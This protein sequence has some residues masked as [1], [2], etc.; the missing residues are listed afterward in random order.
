MSDQIEVIEVSRLRPKEATRP[1][2]IER[3]VGDLSESDYRRRPSPVD[4]FESYRLHR[5][6]FLLMVVLPTL[7]A[8]LYYGLWASDQYAAEVRFGVRQ[9]QQPNVSDDVLAKMAQGMAVGTTG[10]EPYLVA[11]YVRSRNLVEELDRQIG[12]REIYSRPAA[13]FF[14]RFDP[15]GSSEKLWGYWRDMVTV[16]ADRFSGLVTVRALAF[17]PD[18]AVTIV[19]AVQVSAEQIIDET[20]QRPRADALHF[21]EDELVRARQRYVDSLLALR[22]VREGAQTVDPATAIE[23]T[24]KTLTGAIRQKL[25]LERDLAFNMKVVSPSAPQIQV[26]NQ[27]LRAVNEQIAALNR[28]LTSRDEAD[29]TAADVISRFEERE[30]ARRFSEKLMEITQSSYER[31]RVEEARQHTYLTSFVEPVR[32]DQAEYPRRARTIGLIAVLA[33]VVWTI[34]LILVAAVKDHKLVSSGYSG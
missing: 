29:R 28:L 16:N 14:A 9:T 12:L 15:R 1:Q 25:A 23:E 13:D 31:A 21:A 26:L 34:T 4:R 32:P 11:N 22:R 2:P 18:D 24:A 30:L 17:T 8:C 33:L 20:S 7:A 27:R 3:P 19:R 10:R 6:T 5:I